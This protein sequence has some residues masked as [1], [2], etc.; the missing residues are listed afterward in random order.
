MRFPVP[1]E[2]IVAVSGGPTAASA[3]Y[4]TDASMCAFSYDR[5]KAYRFPTYREARL[6]VDA[7]CRIVPEEPDYV[8]LR[9]AAQ[10]AIVYATTTEAAHAV[11]S[12]AEPGA[13][14]RF[15]AAL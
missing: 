5:A 2:R 15:L 7:V 3:L 13:L 10:Y 12:R 8:D 1:T 9:L 11:I 4:A 6:A 14:R